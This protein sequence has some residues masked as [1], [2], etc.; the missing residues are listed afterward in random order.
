MS[1]LELPEV[2]EC[3]AAGCSYNHDHVCHAGAITISG[4][5]ED[6]ACGTFIDLG[7]SGG[8]PTVVAR[9]GACHRTDCVHNSDLECTAEAIRV[10]PGQDKA[11]CLT[12]QMRI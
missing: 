2:D 6:A 9:V 1:V 5:P 8:L 7:P 3:A 11:D 4:T 10:G 12:Y